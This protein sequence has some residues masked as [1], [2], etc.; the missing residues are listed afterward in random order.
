MQVVDKCSHLNLQGWCGTNPIY[1]LSRATHTFVTLIFVLDALKFTN[2]GKNEQ[3]VHSQ[4]SQ[5]EL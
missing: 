1:L 2:P 4:A 5:D 3:C